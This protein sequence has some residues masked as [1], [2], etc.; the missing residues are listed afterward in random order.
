MPLLPR[1]VY[2]WRRASQWRRGLARGRRQVGQ[3]AALLWQASLSPGAQPSLCC[4]TFRLR[5]AGAPSPIGS[6]CISPQAAGCASTPLAAPPTTFAAAALPRAAPAGPPLPL[7]VSRGATASLD[8]ST[9]AAAGSGSGC[10]HQARS[11]W[12][13]G[14]E[15]GC[16]LAPSNNASAA[17]RLGAHRAV[18][19]S[20]GSSRITCLRRATPVQVGSPLGLVATAAAGRRCCSHAPAGRPIPLQWPPSPM[21]QRVSA[22]SGACAGCC[23]HSASACRPRGA[24]ARG[25]LC[26]GRGVRAGVSLRCRSSIWAKLLLGRAA[27]VPCQLSS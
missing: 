7:A 15:Q 20:L 26:V 17:M 10:K 1:C 2:G 23:Q 13:R 19:A 12:A 5:H 18:H 14:A 8:A 24:G 9:T 3:A 22:G 6:A 21:P 4:T 25:L 16:V 27:C 11:R